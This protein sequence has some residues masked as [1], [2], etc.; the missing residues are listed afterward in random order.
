[1]FF[2]KKS[3]KSVN[4]HQLN[5]AGLRFPNASQTQVNR[6]TIATDALYN[7]LRLAVLLGNAA[8]DRYKDEKG[9]SLAGTNNN[10]SHA[11]HRAYTTAAFQLQMS[12]LLK[13][14]V[15]GT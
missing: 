15:V 2:K 9:K 10:A 11:I 3:G 4:E 6:R 12:H 1:L 7:Q 13:C 8:L 5:H 14:A